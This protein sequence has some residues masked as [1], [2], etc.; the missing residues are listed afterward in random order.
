[1]TI[2]KEQSVFIC[3]RIKLL[4]MPEFQPLGIALAWEL[5]ELMTQKALYESENDP[6]G[7][8]RLEADAEWM[9]YNKAFPTYEQ[10]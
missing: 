5:S 3:D 6:V 1:M 10:I 9:A 8:A 2:T 4:Q 7:T